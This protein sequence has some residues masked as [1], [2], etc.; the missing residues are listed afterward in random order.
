MGNTIDSSPPLFCAYSLA[1]IE[2]IKPDF[3]SVFCK[4]DHLIDCLMEKPVDF[5]CVKTLITD[6]S[7]LF[8]KINNT[9]ERRLEEF[10]SRCGQLAEERDEITKSE[11]DQKI[12]HKLVRIIKIKPNYSNLARI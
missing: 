4:L 3:E 1:L 6:S 2:E 7:Q 12:E 11:S 8:T 9:T 5:H 10:A